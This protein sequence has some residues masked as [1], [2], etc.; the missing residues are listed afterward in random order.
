[1]KIVKVRTRKQRKLFLEYTNV[2]YKGNEYFVP[3]LYISE[4]DIFKKDYYYYDDCEAEYFLAF[5]GEG[6]VVGRIGAF[7][8]RAS[9][10]KTGEKRARFC[11]FDCIDDQTVADALF[12][13]AVKWAKERGMEKICGPLGFSDLEREGLLIEGFDVVQTFEEQYN[14]PYYQKLIENYGFKKDVDWLEYQIRLKPGAADKIYRVHDYLVRNTKLRFAQ[15]KNIKDFVD[16]YAERIFDL[17]DQCYSHLYGTVDLTEKMRKE[18]IS[19]FKLLLTTDY[20]LAIVDENDDLIAFGLVFPNIGEA[21][22]IAGGH[23]TPRTILR[24]RKIMKKPKIIDLGLIAVRP[25]YQN[26][27]VNSFFMKLMADWLY[28]RKVEHFETNL[29]LES[30]DQVQAQWKYFDAKQV[31]RRRSFIMDI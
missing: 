17:I 22:R 7:I 5:N 20:V 27:G 16:R 3:P 21:M 2:L 1:M 13:E 18:L 14:Y 8:Q 10:E 31:K 6:E 25:D 19:Q 23:L 9:N 4:K 24:I 15:S 29:N 26:K 11:R 28:E 30:N 12:D